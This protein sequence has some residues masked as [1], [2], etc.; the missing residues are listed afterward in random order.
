MH[1]SS[2]PS[3]QRIS[4]QDEQ[5]LVADAQKDLRH[6]QT[7]YEIY[8]ARI[9]KYCYLHTLDS[10]E[11]EDLTSQTFLRALEAFPGFVWKE[12][13]FGAWLYTMAGNLVK[14]HY[15][16][17]KHTISLDEMPELSQSQTTVGWDMLNATERK[18]VVRELLK[19]LA[20]SCKYVLILRFF[21]EFTYDMIAQRTESTE[22]ACK[23]QVKRCLE[24]L[25]QEVLLKT[26]EIA[27]THAAF[28]K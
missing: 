2:H 26:P 28:V 15:R 7:L 16:N 14:N 9:Y 22:A 13:P 23:M 27:A 25:R 17:R 19:D 12:V 5:Q 6:F 20:A 11:A 21:E 3:Y 18:L 1:N 10:A 24:R 8:F 4:L